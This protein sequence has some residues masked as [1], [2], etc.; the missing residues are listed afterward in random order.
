MSCVMPVIALAPALMRRPGSTSCWYSA[1]RTP[2]STRAMPISITRSPHSADAPVVSTSTNASGISRSF[3]IRENGIGGAPSPWGHFGFWIADFGLNSRRRWNAGRPPF[4]PKSSIQNP[5]SKLRPDDLRLEHELTVHDPLRLARDAAVALGGLLAEDV[6]LLTWRDL[7]AEL[8]PVD[9]AEPDEP[10]PADE[11]SG[12]E[13]RELRRALDHQNAR[14][15]WPPGD[16]AGDPELVV[17]DVL[18]AEDLS[19]LRVD[20]RDAVQLLHVAAL[21]VARADGFL[22]E[23]EAFQVDRGNVEEQLWRH[24]QRS[25]GRGGRGAEKRKKV[26]GAGRAGVGDDPGSSPPSFYLFPT[27]RAALL[28]D[29]RLGLT[30]F[31]DLLAHVLGG[32]LDFLHFL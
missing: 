21:R 18:E 23:D 30:T 25:R 26:K 24:K 29:A 27:A 31:Q 19:L 5:K 17:A 11:F 16:V 6:H 3:W 4:N 12:V 1:T 15:Q 20:V 2:P 8:A 32:G 28:G 22:V 7:L 13:R 10:L 14:Q 9:P